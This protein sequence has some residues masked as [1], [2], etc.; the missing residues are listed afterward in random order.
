M[1]LQIKTNK[2]GQIHD[3]DLTDKEWEKIKPLLPPPKK[4]GR[5]RSND[6]ETINGIIYVLSTGI[7]WNDMPKYYPSGVTCW[8]R[9][10]DWEEEGAWKKIQELVLE[11]LYK[12]GKL[13]L[14]NAYLDSSFAETKKGLSMRS[15]T[16]ENIRE[17]ESNDMR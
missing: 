17:R 4:T 6:R 15:V 13:N 1:E 10:R 5:K 2:R 8:R 16:M 14:T 9:L 3:S 11:E 7:R 12:R